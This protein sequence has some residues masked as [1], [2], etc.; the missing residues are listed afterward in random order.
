MVRGVP[1]I[2]NQTHYLGL[3]GYSPTVSI[4]QAGCYITSL[5]I[6]SSYYGKHVDP[7]D[8]DKAFLDNKLFAP[9][10]ALVGSDANLEVIFPDIVFQETLLFPNEPP[11]PA[12]LGKLTQLMADP[13][14]SV[15]LEIDRG[16]GNTHFVV[17]LGV[18]GTVTIANPWT[19]QVEDFTV[20][21]G[22]PVKNIIKFV[23]YKGT[24]IS[25]DQQLT[26]QLRQQRDENWNL[27]QAQ[28]GLV[29]QANSQLQE[30]QLKNGDLTKKLSDL[31]SKY[32]AES[33]KNIALNEANKTI[34]GENQDNGQKALDAEHLVATLQSYL[35]A[36][37]DRL[38]IKS[39]GLKDNDIA[40]KCLAEIDAEKTLTQAQHDK[41]QALQKIKLVTPQ[42]V[43]DLKKNVLLTSFRKL[44]SLFYTSA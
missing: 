32:D 31:Q 4:A 17:C 21:Y 13:S 33:T 40:D 24:P 30:E 28:V 20:L 39:I 5:A 3:L 10:S 15:I 35:Y 42:V 23:V 18:N 41:I 12:D 25:I 26:D 19:G 16:G 38:D 29:K 7:V 1:V 6:I 8:L 9:D 34:S 2:Y 11:T 22:D 27:Y 14:V 44:L 37:A 43:G 36:V